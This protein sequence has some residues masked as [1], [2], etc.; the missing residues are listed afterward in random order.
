MSC[1]SS[2]LSTFFVD[3]ELDTTCDLKFESR[4]GSLS[5]Q[6]LS[7]FEIRQGGG[8]RFKEKNDMCD[9]GGEGSKSSSFRVLYF[10][11]GPL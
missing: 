10:L 11:N 5:L 6:S 1:D 8:Q 7:I 9:I 4:I 2:I 3:V